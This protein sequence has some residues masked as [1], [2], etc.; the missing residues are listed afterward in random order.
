[1]LARDNYTRTLAN[2]AA[3]A[4][5]KRDGELPIEGVLIGGREY[6]PG[7]RVVARRNDRRHDLDN[8]TLGTVM[9][10]DE[11]SSAI[12]I[13][14]DA[15]ELCVVDAAYAA[16]HLEHAYALTAHSAQ[17]ATFDWA[18]VI[19]RPE[20][21]T[22]EWAYTALSRARAQTILHLV[23]ERPA[24]ERERDEYAPAAPERDPTEGRQALANA[25]RRTEI[26]QLAIEKIRTTSP[27]REGP[28]ST[29]EPPAPTP[30]TPA[31]G[32]S[33]PSRLK[34]IDALRA[35]TGPRHRARATL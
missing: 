29:P 12:V 14:T 9:N 7:D 1:M 21:F 5:L 28:A 4:Q 19:G 24:R 23:M 26:E 30:A 17:G 3:R 27:A 34:G 31:T 16:N 25:I 32:H 18:G 35:H 11:R 20:E 10:V 15:G 33:R 22:R 2:R 13:R 8:G 6:A